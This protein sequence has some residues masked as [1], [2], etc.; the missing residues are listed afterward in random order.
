MFRSKPK[1]ICVGSELNF[2]GSPVWTWVRW[3]Q[4]THLCFWHL[5]FKVIPRSICKW[6]WSIYS[7]ELRICACDCSWT[8]KILTSLG[9]NT[10]ILKYRFDADFEVILR[11]FFTCI[12][13]QLFKSQ[14][15][16]AWCGFLDLHQIHVRLDWRGLNANLAWIVSLTWT[17][18]FSAEYASKSWFCDLGF[19]FC[20]VCSD[21]QILL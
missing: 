9:F 19:K 20:I 4:Y 11:G 21:T 1:N 7:L 17:G 2:C 8:L 3:V 10:Q 18:R 5:A 12:L 6:L 16:V 15:K 13:T 14:A